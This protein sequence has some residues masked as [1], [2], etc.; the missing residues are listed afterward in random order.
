MAAVAY[1]FLVRALIRHHGRGSD[2]AQAFGL[3]TKGKLSIVAYV[4]GVPLSLVYSWLGLA[5]YFAVA[6]AWFIPDRRVEKTTAKA[7]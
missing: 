1:Y 6:L 7:D 4:F 2:F 5:I 3:D